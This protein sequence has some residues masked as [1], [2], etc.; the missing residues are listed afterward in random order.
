MRDDGDENKKEDGNDAWG[1]AWGVGKYR[2]ETGSPERAP[3]RNATS[4]FGNEQS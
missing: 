1:E 3:A 2:L 4:Q